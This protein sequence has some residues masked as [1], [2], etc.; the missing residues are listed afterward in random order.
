MAYFNN[1]DIPIAVKDPHDRRAP[2]VTSLKA[3][4]QGTFTTTQVIH[5]NGNRYLLH[6]TGVKLK[7]GANDLTDQELLRLGEQL[8]IPKGVFNTYC[9]I[10]HPYGYPAENYQF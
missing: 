6:H 2:S 4:P 8:N 7:I 10:T 1:E 5:E 3:Q 9:D